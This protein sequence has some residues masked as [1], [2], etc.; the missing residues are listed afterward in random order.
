MP[1]QSF[2]HVGICCSDLEQST[3]FYVE[4][5]RFRELFTVELGPEV[6]STMEVDGRFHSRMLARDDVRLELLC[7]LEP[8]GEGARARRSMTQ[9]G[10]T[11]L[12]FRV[13]TIDELWEIA[14]RYGGDPL[15][16]TLS[17]MVGAG[18]GGAD[19]EMVHL[20]DPDDVRI[21]CMTG[22]PDL[23]SAGHR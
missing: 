16:Q 4:V 20:T 2:S 14:A 3:R 7:W 21:E 6:A 15:P 13:D 8:E 1:L 23:T 5:L 12:A 9:F 17:R 10:L 18:V 11:H 22:V 19:A